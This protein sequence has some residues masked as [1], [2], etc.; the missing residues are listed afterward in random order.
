MDNLKLV[1]LELRGM[2]MQLLFNVRAEI[3]WKNDPKSDEAVDREHPEAT[4]R[5]VYIMAQEGAAACRWY[6]YDPYPLPTEQELAEYFSRALMWE[7]NDVF[8]AID[9][10]I[11][12]STHRDYLPEENKE[13]LIDSIELKKD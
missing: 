8:W 6:G 9:E 13:H 11:K 10:A 7:M 3:A 12:I 2:T 1:R 4:A 5:I